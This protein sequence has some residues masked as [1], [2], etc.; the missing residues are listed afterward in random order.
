MVFPPAAEVDS[1]LKIDLCSGGLAVKASKAA[2]S[3]REA[4]TGI[5]L[6]VRPNDSRLMR[7]ESTLAA[8]SR[9]GETGLSSGSCAGSQASAAGR[10][11]CGHSPCATHSVTATDSS[12]GWSRSRSLT[13]GWVLVGTAAL[14]PLALGA[15]CFAAMEKS[16]LAFARPSNPVRTRT[17]PL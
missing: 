11:G 12:S 15:L 8:G 14:P 10:R 5:A 4:L 9:G 16:S 17:L 6:L 2:A 7:V 1:R 3:L 13:A